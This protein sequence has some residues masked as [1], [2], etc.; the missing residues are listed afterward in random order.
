LH[1]FLFISY[2]FN[3]FTFCQGCWH[4]TDFRHNKGTIVAALE[5]MT[6][7]KI[8]THKT[9]SGTQGRLRGALTSQEIAKYVEHCLKPGKVPG[10]D[11]CPHKPLLKTMSDEE[12]LI[13]Q[14]W[15]N[16]LLTP[17]EKTP[18]LRARVG[19]PCGPSQ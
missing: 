18:T 11:K 4:F 15:V 7:L 16:E 19:T 14:A 6:K 17:P 10:P 1:K 13:V 12:F 8:D 2:L 5:L 3:L 9:A